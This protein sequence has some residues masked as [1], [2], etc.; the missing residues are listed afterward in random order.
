MKCIVGSCPPAASWGLSG[1]AVGHICNFP[2]LSQLIFRGRHPSAPPGK[3]GKC[4]HAFRWLSLL[5]Q[6]QYTMP[7]VSSG[8]WGSGGQPLDWA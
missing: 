1:E 3:A 2:Y 6:P 4:P 5:I 7:H 8:E